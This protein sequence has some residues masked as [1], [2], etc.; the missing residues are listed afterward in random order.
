MTMKKPL[1]TTPLMPRGAKTLAGALLGALVGFAGCSA[2]PVFLP[3]HDLDRPTDIAFSCLELDQ[4]A[5]PA[6]PAVLGAQ[7]MDVCHPPGLK[8]PLFGGPVTGDDGI[9][10]TFKTYAFVTNSQRGDVSVVDM[11]YCRSNDDACKQHA[12]QPGAALVDLDPNTIGYGSAPVGEIP[13]VIDASQDGCRLVTAN[14]GSCDLTFI[15]PAAMLT[16][17]LTGGALPT[18]ART[19]MV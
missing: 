6:T 7:P 15:D 19:F 1:L 8:D 14:R 2:Q 3:S 11:S 9:A 13:E 12:L 16:P 10:R 17:R 4:P 18:Y 5:D